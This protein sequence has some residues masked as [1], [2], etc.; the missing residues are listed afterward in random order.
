MDWTV[1]QIEAHGMTFLLLPS[2]RLLLSSK[3]VQIP[4]RK[5]PDFRDFFLKRLH[6][7]TPGNMPEVN[8]VFFTIIGLLWYGRIFFV[9][10]FICFWHSALALRFEEIAD[11]D[12]QI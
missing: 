7:Q 8:T 10:K 4:G 6:Q 5:L 9:Q 3:S 2:Y 11:S 12:L 1:A